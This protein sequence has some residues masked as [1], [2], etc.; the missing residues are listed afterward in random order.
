MV[1]II[2]SIKRN[3]SPAKQRSNS[4]PAMYFS[5]NSHTSKFVIYPVCWW[6]MNTEALVQ[7]LIPSV[8]FLMNIFK[9]KT[10]IIT[11]NGKIWMRSR[12]GASAEV[13]ERYSAKCPCELW[14]LQFFHPEADSATSQEGHNVCKKV[15]TGFK[16]HYPRGVNFF[17][18]FW[19]EEETQCNW[20]WSRRRMTL[21][22]TF[23][24]NNIH[25]GII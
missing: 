5:I 11:G 18:I 16:L 12:P 14:C 1:T 10:S 4:L 19:K 25:K 15:A 13:T 6:I 7:V 17:E 9:N 22:E 20:H 3:A 24:H 2:E 8:W 21:N 23:G